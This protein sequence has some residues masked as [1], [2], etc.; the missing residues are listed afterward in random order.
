MEIES[1]YRSDLCMT[2]GEISCT[3]NYEEALKAI[4]DA[5]HNCLSADGSSLFLLD[6]S[7]DKFSIAA[8]RGL[9]EKAMDQPPIALQEG[10]TGARLLEGHEVAIKDLVHDPT[11]EKI[12]RDEGLRSGLAAPLRSRGKVIG[13]LLAFS[14]EPRDFS[15]DEASYLLTLAS[16]GGVTLGNARQHRD[17]HLIAEVGRAVTSRRDLREILRQ[18]VESAKNLFA[19]KGAAVYLTNPEARTLEV[20]ASY[21]LSDGF[22]EKDVLKI[23]DTVQECLERLVVIPDA[24]KE[25]EF[26]FPEHLET[27]GLRSVICTPLK[28]KDKPIGVLRL[29]MTRLRELSHADRMLIGIL[30]DFSAISIENARL[31][32]HIVRDYEDLTRDVWQWYD[33]GERPPKT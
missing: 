33:W 8:V 32:N 11:F 14:R 17:L 20:K 25:R 5:V 3:L 2:C 31:Y 9:S 10:S 23:D 21:G 4:L 7:N 30:A 26:P 16:Q 29:Y 19:A 28:V 12:A 24:S 27:E 22:F 15:A 18:I 6:L 1:Q 13:A